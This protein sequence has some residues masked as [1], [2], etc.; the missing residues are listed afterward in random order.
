MMCPCLRHLD[1]S[2]DS[3][4]I[5]TISRL[6]LDLSPTSLSTMLDNSSAVC[7]DLTRIWAPSHHWRVLLHGGISPAM[8]L[9]QTWNRCGEAAPR[10][11]CGDSLLTV[12]PL[13]L[14]VGK[15]GCAI[16]PTAFYSLAQRET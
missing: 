14:R 10:V 2:W 4:T 12:L 7:S 16:S 6:R 11:Y 15:Y 1:T 5:L 13:V 3:C 8:V 9:S